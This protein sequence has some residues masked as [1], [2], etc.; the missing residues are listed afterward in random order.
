MVDMQKKK[1]GDLQKLQSYLQQLSLRLDQ[2]E[3]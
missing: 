2:E 3:E 1:R